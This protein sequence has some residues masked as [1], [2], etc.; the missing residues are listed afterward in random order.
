MS[1]TTLEDLLQIFQSRVIAVD[2]RLLRVLNEC[3]DAGG[4]GL[5][6]LTEPLRILRIRPQDF[7]QDDDLVLAAVRPGKFPQFGEQSIL[8]GGIIRRSLQRLKYGNVHQRRF[9]QPV[10]TAEIEKLQ[11]PRRLQKRHKLEQRGTALRNRDR[12]ARPA[13]SQQFLALVETPVDI[14]DSRSILLQKLLQQRRIREVRALDKR[15]DAGG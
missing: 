15:L 4:F 11:S 14:G 2:N 8:N 12:L 7:P 1:S 5:F 9:R 3:G 6:Q 13:V 10:Q